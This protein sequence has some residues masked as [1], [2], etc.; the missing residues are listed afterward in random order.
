[1]ARDRNALSMQVDTRMVDAILS[2]LRDMPREMQK[3]ELAAVQRT[4][5]TAKSKISREVRKHTPLAKKAVDD[6]IKTIRRPRAGS[7]YT[8]IS[9]SGY[10]ISLWEYSG[11]KSDLKNFAAQKG[12]KVKRRKPRGGAGWKI[13]KNEGRTRNKRFVA[14]RKT[15]NKEPVIIQRM[16]GSKRGGDK[17]RSPKDYRTAYGP[18][19][20]WLVRKR[21]ILTPTVHELASTLEKNLRSQVDRFLKRKKSDRPRG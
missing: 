13:W 3:A 16:P 4:A 14:T 5:K 1:M 15:K 17:A 8:V 19:L 21:N 9:L 10:Q 2:E 20:A 6:R 11:S 12:V 7:A 18:S